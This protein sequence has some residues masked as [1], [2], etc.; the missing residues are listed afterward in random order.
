[1]K[2][3]LDGDKSDKSLASN[4]FVK[5][6][7]II[8]FF[9]LFCSFS[10]FADTVS[11][12][13]K[14]TIKKNNV[15]LKEVLNEIE[16]QTNYLFI[17][18][19]EVNVNRL[20]SIHVTKA[21]V[22][23]ILSKLFS[24][25]NVSYALEGVHIVLTKNNLE[26]KIFSAQQDKNDKITGTVTDE[27]GDPLIGVSLVVQ[28]SNNG[29]IT[30][31]NGSFV[32]NAKNGSILVVSY[33]GYA[34]T[35]IKASTGTLNIVLKE[36][37][38]RLEEVVVVGYGAQKKINLTGAVTA[39]SGK[40]MI[41]RPVLNAASMLQGQVPGL[42]VVQSSGQ[43]GAESASFRI[44]GQ[45]TYSSAG[46]DPLILI[47]GV[48]G[49]L[50]TLD[51]SIIESVSVLKD[52]A[53]ASIYG[54]RAANGVVLVTTKKGSL[55]SSGKN[56][57]AIYS[58]NLS[59][60]TPTK[61]LNT[62]TNSAEYMTLFNQAKKNS[63]K[64]GLYD[65]KDIQLYRQKGG[66]VE[67]PNF[68]WIDYMFDPA[69]VQNHNVSL[70][71]NTEKITYN[72]A[73]NLADQPGTMRG[74]EYKKYNFSV[75]LSSQ[76][77]KWLKVGTYI[78]GNYGD[79]KEPRNGASDAFLC[80]L[81]QSP[82]AMPWLPDDGS[83][84]IRY[85]FGAYPNIEQSNKNMLAM[86]VFGI[87]TQRK[88][89]DLNGQFYIE[90]TPF[91]GFKWHSKLAGRLND[92]KMKDWSGTKVP[93]YDYHTGEMV[94]NMD[95]G[96][97]FI[98]G[99]AIQDGQTVYTNLYSF[100]E[101]KFPFANSEH[102]MTVMAGY[103][104]EKNTYDVLWAKRI[105]Y[106]FNLPEL[107]A[108]SLEKR[109]N[110]GYKEEWAIMSGFFR[111]N[112][113]Y[114]SVYLAEVSA[115]YDGTSR[116]ASEN[117]WGVFPS[118]SLG[119]RIS[120]EK[121]M[122]NLHFDWLTNMKIRASWG[123]LGNQNIGLYPYQAIIN[124]TDSYSFDNST[125]TQG[126]AQTDYV[127]RDLQWETTTISDIGANITLFNRL[128]I[129]FDWYSKKTT[130]ILRDAQVSSFIGLKPPTVNNGEMVNKGIELSV[131]WQDVIKAGF[132][133]GFQYNAGFYIDSSRNK[134]SKFGAEEKKDNT[135]LREGI[136]YDSFYMLKSVGIFADQAEIDAS[137][138][139][140]S[141][142]TKPGDIKYS[143]ANKDGKVD[144]DDRIVIDGRF[145]DF[146]YSFNAGAFWKGF[147]LS[148]M[149]Q[150]VSGISS[151]VGTGAGIAPFAQG[152]IITKDYIEGMWTEKE[153]YGATNPRLY[154]ADM[155]GG[156]NTR[157]SSYYL[158]DAS[159]LRLKNLVLGYTFPTHWTRKAAIQRLRLFFSG[160]NLLTFTNYEGLDPENG[161]SFL[162]YPQNKVFSF[163]INVE[164]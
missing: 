30:D 94:R 9:F 137:P 127:N 103:N 113:D 5:K 89:F 25:Q 15:T 2:N 149:F 112:Y 62:I 16:N 10:L 154:F 96:G 151:Y 37:T 44:R 124:L 84:N 55:S 41:K 21:S 117:R 61:M 68:N 72:I 143:D 136:P 162:K 111:L 66:S 18:S 110:S 141:D 56:F 67:Y 52:A 11:Q 19:N 79:R 164:F 139:Q 22:D 86:S 24:E 140:F 114:K 90:L 33:I 34:T 104:Q 123:Q 160:D 125:L 121:Y 77:T 133:K 31:I 128:N 80:T 63:G 92:E 13:A 87:N 116:I 97:G 85:T 58:G 82:T 118:F 35:T 59:I 6:L 107:D 78:S 39:V 53:S 115:R 65:E 108:G 60:Y 147:D 148:I 130:D 3:K 122:K 50:S 157:A 71:G 73:M 129:E 153:P 101:Y 91:K 100:I 99:L 74:F 20:V 57:S 142:V 146:E 93:L 70:S 150:G 43:P 156:R 1:M 75:D 69:F 29:T 161:D 155:G 102:N 134:L 88:T 54:S 38:Q 163:G 7:R 8:T 120:E 42:R 81:A 26:K 138:K 106:Q 131:N 145:P 36:D 158:R 4:C 47:N 144:Y 126:V 27:K 159:Y 64:S 40:E 48:P 83:G 76:L 32:L 109:E 135:I 12:M 132:F 49:S 45:G 98:P 28:G 95:L 46:S 119:Y 23:Y 51:P 14:V 17:Y 152:S 105:D